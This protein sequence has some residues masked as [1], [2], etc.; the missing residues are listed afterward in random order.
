MARLRKQGV[1]I[2]KRAYGRRPRPR[3]AG[4]PAP[5][6][7]VEGA[8][9]QPPKAAI[10]PVSERNSSATMKHDPLHFAANYVSRKLFDTL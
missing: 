6:E 9:G 2:M 8:E 5:P 4:R 3:A 1:A 10:R 7:L